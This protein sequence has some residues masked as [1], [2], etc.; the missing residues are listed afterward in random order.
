MW[1]KLFE[2]G[3]VRNWVGVVCVLSSLNGGLL[4]VAGRSLV[5]N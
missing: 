3:W 4:S 2:F 1:F 5:N